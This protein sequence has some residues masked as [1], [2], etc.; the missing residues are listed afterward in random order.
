MNEMKQLHR[1]SDLEKGMRVAVRWP[2]GYKKGTVLNVRDFDETDR[3]VT[4]EL[5]ETLS[6]ISIDRVESVLVER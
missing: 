3:G 2:G 5:D 6:K 4:V 1:W